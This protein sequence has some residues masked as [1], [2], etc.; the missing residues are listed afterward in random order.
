MSQHGNPIA[1]TQQFA[2]DLVGN[3]I[4]F[5]KDSA[6]T[7]YGYAASSNQ[8]L[9][10]TGA[11]ARTYSYDAVGNPTAI[12]GLNYVYNNANRLVT[13]LNGAATVASY[14]VNAL[15]QR[16]QKTAGGVLVTAAAFC[17]IEAFGSIVVWNNDSIH[18]QGTS[19]ISEPKKFIDDVFT[20][21][22]SVSSAHARLGVVAFEK[23]KSV[24]GQL[25]FFVVDSK[26]G[27]WWKSFERPGL[28]RAALSPDG[29]R[30]AFLVCDADSCELRLRQLAISGREEVIATS[31]S[32]AG[33]PSWN[34]NGQQLAV[35]NSVGWIDVIDVI[36]KSKHPLVKGA[37][38]SWSRDG[39]RL[40]YR[41][42]KAIWIYS[43]AE[44]KPETK[45]Y[46]RHFWQSNIVGPVNWG[47]R[48]VIAFNVA[49]GIDGYQIACLLID[50]ESEGV[51]ALQQGYLW[52]GPWL[53]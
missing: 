20:N 10:L 53:E 12:G 52:C 41:P 32:R 40:A 22:V 46:Q 36:T 8:L 5:T 14:K 11:T 47:P 2:F 16:L 49:A 51:T 7:N 33:Q 43:L 35:E 31:L 38:P 26:T 29:N 39:R 37:N 21:I 9:N 15:G 18:K 4:N 17:S 24:D 50:A 42:E 13:V 48:N 34:P 1:S 3:R 28:L 45:V 23:G 6:L 19:P 27:Q 44:Q 25:G 30:V